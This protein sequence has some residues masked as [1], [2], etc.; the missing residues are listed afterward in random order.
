VKKFGAVENKVFDMSAYAGVSQEDLSSLLKMFQ[1]A[2]E[3]T[4]TFEQLTLKL[5]LKQ[6]LDS[7]SAQVREMFVLQFILGREME[8][9]QRDSKVTA[10]MER[11]GGV[12]EAH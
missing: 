6:F 7:Q 8:R 12:D 2:R 9:S 1:E 10:L 3:A 11:M 4:K 5:G